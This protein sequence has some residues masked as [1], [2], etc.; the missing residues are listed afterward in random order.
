MRANVVRVRRHERKWL[1]R[2]TSATMDHAVVLLEPIVPEDDIFCNREH[3]TA[4]VEHKAICQ[5]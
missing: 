1:R 4:D 3:K 5:A 2:I